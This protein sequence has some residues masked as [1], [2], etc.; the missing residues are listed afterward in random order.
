MTT[1]GEFPFSVL[2]GRTD[3][4]FAGRLPGGKKIYKDEDNWFCSGVLL[5]NRFVL[6][7]A[8]CKT[9]D[10]TFKL[11]IGVHTLSKKLLGAVDTNS[12]DLPDL[13]DFYIK[14]ENFVIHEFYNQTKENRKTVISNDIAL[15]KLPRPAQFNQLAQPSCWRSKKP[16]NDKLVVVGWGKT[17]AYQ[18]S[19]TINGAFSNNQFK[20]EV[21]K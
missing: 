5:N 14:P 21:M 9:D 7:A 8:H 10:E 11:R 1:P 15:I 4:K 20:L 16:I 18:I 3:K 13:Q 19:K 2:I 6:T 12:A 17:N